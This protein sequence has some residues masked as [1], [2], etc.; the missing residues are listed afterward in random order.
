MSIV[1]GI[2]TAHK[3]VVSRDVIFVEDQL[4]MKDENDSTVKEKSEIVSIHVENNP[5]DSYASE[6]VP[7]HEEQEQVESEALEVQ[8]S[9]HEKWMPAPEHEEQ[10]Q[11]ESKALNVRRLSHERRMPAWHSEYVTEINIAY[12]LLTE[13]RKP[14]TFHETLN[15]S[16]VAFVDGSNVRRNRSSIQE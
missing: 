16:D 6:I 10:E 13:D 11:V 5:E 2:P 14:S 9:T 15:S 4:Q 8:W 1:C 12:C 7:E 3:I